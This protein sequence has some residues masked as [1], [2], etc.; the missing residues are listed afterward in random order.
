MQ[1]PVG[2]AQIAMAQ[3]RRK[4]WQAPLGIHSGAVAAEH[5][6]H[7]YAVPEVMKPRPTPI[8]GVTQSD[9]PRQADERLPGIAADIFAARYGS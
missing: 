9:L 8:R 1:V 4:R 7:G 6:L 2:M 3:I 5:Y